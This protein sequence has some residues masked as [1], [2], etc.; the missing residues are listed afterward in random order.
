MC[1][2][3]NSYIPLIK[4]TVSIVKMDIV[5][6]CSSAPDQSEESLDQQV[7]ERN[8]LYEVTHEQV[9]VKSTQPSTL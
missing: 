9:S 7:S 4:L 5:N 8:A 6:D 1:G 2:A 3:K